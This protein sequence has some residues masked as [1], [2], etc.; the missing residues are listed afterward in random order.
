MN[1]KETY[2]LHAILPVKVKQKGSDKSVTTYPFYDNGSGGCFATESIRKQ[3]GVEGVKVMLRLATMHGESQVEST[4]MDNLVVTRVNDNN[5]IE[6]P[7]S[8][9]R[10][11]FQAGH[12]QIPTP[13]LINQ[14]THLSEIAKK[15]PEFE[16]HFEIG[17]LI[18][19]NCPAALDP[20][21]VVPCQSDGPYA[22]RL[23]HGW[24]VSGPLRIKT[25]HD[26][27]KI[28]ANRITMREV[29]KTQKEII[30]QNVRNGLQ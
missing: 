1:N 24:T 11:E 10:D 25:K 9:T 15:I 6:L 17:L 23:R 22:L 3:L 14:W 8:Y 19:S 18:G 7:G 4:I 26:G 13:D 5:P 30:A 27:D 20:L 21:E 12:R 29:V 2:V 16:P 28:I